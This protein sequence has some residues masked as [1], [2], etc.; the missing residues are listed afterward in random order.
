MKALRGSWVDFVE[1]RSEGDDADSG[2]LKID[3]FR[4]LRGS[5]G[6]GAF[7]GSYRITLVQNAE[8]MTSQAANSLLKVL[9]EPPPGWIFFLTAADPSLL[10]PTLVSRC[11]Q[12]KLQPLPQD[13]VLEILTE[14]QAPEERRALAAELSQGSLDRARALCEDE[15]WEA[16]KAILKFIEEPQAELV[17][18]IDWA[19]AEPKNLSLLMDQLE[20]LLFDLIRSNTLPVGGQKRFTGDGRKALERH[21]ETIVK[22][23]GSKERAREFWQARAERLFRARKEAL[24]PLNKKILLQDILMPWLHPAS[25]RT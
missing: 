6:F 17:S 5:L 23:R 9:E 20:Q 25:E 11:Q 19:A 24:A 21:T 22:L 13:T 8:R 10:L 15:P 12:L 1:I 4:A 16:R 18:L 14:T 2:T 3:Q 7:D